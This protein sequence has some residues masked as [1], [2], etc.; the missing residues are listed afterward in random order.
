VIVRKPQLLML[1]LAVTAVLTGCPQK[2]DTTATPATTPTSAAE[3]PAPAPE[4]PPTAQFAITDLDSS[5]NVCDNLADFVNSKWL[6]ANPI[7]S[8]RTTWGS[9]EILGERSLAA[10]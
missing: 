6:A 1:S 10:N 4:L 5:K 7:P 2:Q 3:T 9:F 8:D